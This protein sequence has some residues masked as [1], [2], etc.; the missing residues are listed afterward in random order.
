MTTLAELIPAG[1]VLRLCASYDRLPRE[2]C[3]VPDRCRVRICRR[4]Q[5][6]VH[7]DPKVSIP[8]LGL[9]YILCDICL[10]E[11]MP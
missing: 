5:R 9:E 6:N 4:C 7:W 3:A 11:V 10:D 1:H 8:L 2:R